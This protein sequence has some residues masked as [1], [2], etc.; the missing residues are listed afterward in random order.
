MEFK[1]KFFTNERD[2]VNDSYVVKYNKNN[3]GLNLIDYIRNLYGNIDIKN[4]VDNTSD[5][6]M[7][8]YTISLTEEMARK[9]GTK[10]SLDNIVIVEVPLGYLNMFQSVYFIPRYCTV[11]TFFISKKVIEYIDI[12]N[13]CKKD[14]VF[15]SWRSDGCPSKWGFDK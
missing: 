11:R 2:N 14:E 5:L 8:S 13:N 6:T 12:Y 3:F 1:V 15:E 7:G 9:C 4:I 10:F